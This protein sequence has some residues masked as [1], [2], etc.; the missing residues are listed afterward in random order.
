VTAASQR[1]PEACEDIMVSGKN[2]CD[3]GRE[4]VLLVWESHISTAAEA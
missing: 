1:P 3:G 4:G 2:D